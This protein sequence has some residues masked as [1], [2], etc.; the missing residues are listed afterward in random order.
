MEFKN[1]PIV[2][3]KWEIVGWIDKPDYNSLDNLVEGSY[4]YKEIY[5]GR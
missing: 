1:D 5:A 3:G 2:I 4:G